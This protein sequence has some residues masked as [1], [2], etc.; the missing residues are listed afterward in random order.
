MMLFYLDSTGSAFASFAFIDIVK[1]DFRFWIVSCSW[2]YF[3]DFGSAIA[4]LVFIVIVE[5]WFYIGLVFIG[6]ICLIYV[7]ILTFSFIINIKN[8]VSYFYILSI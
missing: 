3:V 7:L 5:D 2:I 6:N 1:I 4:S 8:I